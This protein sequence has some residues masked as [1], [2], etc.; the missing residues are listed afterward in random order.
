MGKK[1]RILAEKKRE[2]RCWY[3]NKTAQSFDRAVNYRIAFRF[4]PER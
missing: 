2:K 3:Q 1:G 4:Q